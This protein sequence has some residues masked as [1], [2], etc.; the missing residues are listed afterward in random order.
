LT[1]RLSRVGYAYGLA[2]EN[3]AQ[4]GGDTQDV[5]ALW[6]VS[7]GHDRNLRLSAVQEAGVGHAQG[8][9]GRHFWVLILAT[10]AATTP[11]NPAILADCYT[12]PPNRK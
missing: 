8:P 4:A 3:L 1:Q 5:L 11:E 10:K 2:A 12:I 9:G 6:R 7:P